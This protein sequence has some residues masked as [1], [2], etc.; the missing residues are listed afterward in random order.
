MSSTTSADEGEWFGNATR[1][2]VQDISIAWFV[3]QPCRNNSNLYMSE[4]H[5]MQDNSALWPRENLLAY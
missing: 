2:F 4:R 5:A 3:R 1:R